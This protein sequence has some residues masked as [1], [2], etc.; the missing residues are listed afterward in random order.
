MVSFLLLLLIS[1]VLVLFLFK[2]YISNINT[3]S[4]RP[5]GPKSLPIIGNLHQL[6]SSKLHLQLWEFSKIY[7]PLFSLQIGLKPAIVISSPKLAKEVLKDHDLDVCS[8]PPSLGQQK[9]SYNGLDM[10]FSP[11]NNYWREIRKICVVHLLSSKRISS[12][13]HV[14]SFEVKQMIKKIYGHVC[15]SKVTN[16]SEM[17]MSVSSAVIC[18]IAFGRRYEDE[19]AETSKFHEILNETQAM[20]ITFFV[21]D[22]IPC[23]GWV[24]KLTGSLARLDNTCKALDAFFQE[25]IDEHLDPN[26]EK[27]TKEEDVVDVLLELKKQGQLSIDLTNNHIKAIIMVYIYICLIISCLTTLFSN[28]FINSNVL[29]IG[30]VIELVKTPVQGLMDKTLN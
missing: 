7:G 28:S 10:I 21:S 15:S 19:G 27:G 17:I 11:Y 25:V 12:F 5:P 9:L 30:S 3:P 13:S 24:D 4:T 2:K 22:Y 20:S 26:R 16:L 18:R 29:K 14:R 6:D 1:P 23:M 8:R